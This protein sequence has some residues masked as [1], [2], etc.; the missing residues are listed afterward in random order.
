MSQSDP[1]E[2]AVRRAVEERAMEVADSLIR[3]AVAEYE[4]RLRAEM[5]TIVSD[6]VAWAEINRDRDHLVI[7]VRL[8][9]LRAVNPKA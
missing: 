8:Q 7:T 4:K 5:G 1:I 9:D 2:L 6:V 3:S